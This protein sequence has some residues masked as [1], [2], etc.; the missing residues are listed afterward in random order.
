MGMTYLWKMRSDLCYVLSVRVLL[1]WFQLWLFKLQITNRDLTF[2]GCTFVEITCWKMRST[3]SWVQQ[4]KIYRNASCIWHL[5]GKRGSTMVAHHESSSSCCLESCSTHIMACSNIQ[6]TIPI[7]S[8]CRLCQLLW[9]I[10]MNGKCFYIVDS[11]Y[12][13]GFGAQLQYSHCKLCY[14]WNWHV[15]NTGI[16]GITYIYPATKIYDI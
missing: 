10:S 4:R 1:L 6:Q 7:L 16:F 12:I 9:T 5:T 2:V 14:M 15:S 8:R 13:A 11:L 3:R